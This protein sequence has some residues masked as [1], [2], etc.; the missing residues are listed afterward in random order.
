MTLSDFHN[1]QNV[2]MGASA[3]KLGTTGVDYMQGFGHV[4]TSNVFA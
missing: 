1:T 2:A 3:W 4:R